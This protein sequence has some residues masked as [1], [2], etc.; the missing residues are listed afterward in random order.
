MSRIRSCPDRLEF[1]NECYSTVNQSIIKN[2]DICINIMVRTKT[3]SFL[4]RTKVPK[5]YFHFGQQKSVLP[6][7]LTYTWRCENITA[8]PCALIWRAV[9]EHKYV[10]LVFVCVYMYVSDH[11][12]HCIKLFAPCGPLIGNKQFLSY[13]ILY[14]KLLKV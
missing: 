2:N 5:F 8:S 1:K 12:N 11:F 3:K 13:L 4:K 6:S 9:T 7:L 10:F 14:I